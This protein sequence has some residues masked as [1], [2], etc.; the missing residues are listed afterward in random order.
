MKKSGKIA[1]IAGIAVLGYLAYR[2]YKTSVKEIIKPTE[3]SS[4]ENQQEETS[5]TQSSETST[6]EKIVKEE[7]RLEVNSYMPEL[8][9]DYDLVKSL[10][11]EAT[12]NVDFE[13]DAVKTTSNDLE[14][15]E[16]NI[17]YLIQSTHWDKST[18]QKVNSLEFHL[19]IPRDYDEDFFRMKDFIKAGKKLAL[20]LHNIIKFVEKAH[21]GLCGWLV[22]GLQDEPD[23]ELVQRAIRIPAY[24]YEDSK[25][26]EES[27]SGGL[28]EFV[29]AINNC[30]TEAGEILVKT[31][32]KWVKDEYPDKN[33]YQLNPKGAFLTY[34]ISFD[35]ANPSEKPG[36]NRMGIDHKTGIKCLK[37]ILD[38]FSVIGGN[39][40]VGNDY[41]STNRL[42]Q[43]PKEH[44][45]DKILFCTPDDYGRWSFLRF[46]NYDEKGRIIS[47]SYTWYN[48]YVEDDEESE[49]SDD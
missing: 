21:V 36:V 43:N 19:E 6:K 25:Y 38:E 24:V 40:N 26:A 9:G 2:R 28:E 10:F 39:Y 32:H 34:R 37:Y 22:I 42:P 3:E 20:E 33:M 47:D 13:L 30:E 35:I 17:L 48:G 14:E 31:L 5:G 18:K 27:R 12:K 7:P 15:Y 16:N 11:D 46:Y 23:G 29:A 1:L 44:I 8:E 45:Y 4:E 49:D 41:Y